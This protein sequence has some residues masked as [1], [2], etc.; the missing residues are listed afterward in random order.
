VFQNSYYFYFAKSFYVPY[1]RRLCSAIQNNQIIKLMT[2]R[3]S[4]SNVLTLTKRRV[5]IVGECDFDFIIL[6]H[7]KCHLILNYFW[8]RWFWI[9]Y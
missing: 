7:F 2:F 5:H 3:L 8:F 1:Y 6:N 9:S 4:S